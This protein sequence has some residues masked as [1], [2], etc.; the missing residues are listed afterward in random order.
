MSIM[1]SPLTNESVAY[2]TF[3][4]VKLMVTLY[5]YFTLVSSLLHLCKLILYGIQQS[6]LSTRQNP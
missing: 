2:L 4:K 3:L 5:N 1:H 6:Y